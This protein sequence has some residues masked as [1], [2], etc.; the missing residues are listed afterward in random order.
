M[1]SVSSCQLVPQKVALKKS[2]SCT[3]LVAEVA[4]KIGKVALKLR[5]IWLIFWMYNVTLANFCNEQ[6]NN[7]YQYYMVLLK[8]KHYISLE[9]KSLFMTT[10]GYTVNYAA[11]SLV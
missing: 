4:Q 9:A 2:K 5:A 3:K 11:T 10:I 1:M 8:C 6:Q 7:V